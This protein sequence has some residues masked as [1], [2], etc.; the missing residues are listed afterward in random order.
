M[1]MENLTIAQQWDTLHY[2]IIC[3][4]GYWPQI[5]RFKAR[6]LCLPIIDNIDYFGCD[7]MTCYFTRAKGSAF[8]SAVVGGSRW[9]NMEGP[10]APCHFPNVDG[11][12][13]PSLVVVLVGL[14][15]MLCE[16]V[17]RTT[18]ILICDKCSR[19]WHIGCF[20][21]PMIEMLIGKWFC[22]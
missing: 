19:G 14:R 2:A 20:M 6:G 12:I 7:Y 3:G 9:S 13:D 10:C 17:S 15:C 16:Q 22:P 8:R 11:Q 18:T 4:G 5:W 21:P 1:A